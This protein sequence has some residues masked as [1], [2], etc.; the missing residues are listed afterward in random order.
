MEDF[1]NKCIVTGNR[2]YCTPVMLVALFNVTIRYMI[3]YLKGNICGKSAQGVLL[4]VGGVGYR[5]AVPASF[6]VGLKPGQSIELFIHTHVRE[7]A[8]SLYGFPSQQDMEVFELLISVSGV[9]PKVALA[10]MAHTPVPMIISAI[11]SGDATVFTKVSGVGKKTGERIVVDLQEKMATGIVASGPNA[12]HHS[13]TLDALTALGYSLPEAREALKK[14]EPGV[15]GSSEILKEALK[16][17]G[18]R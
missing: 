8:L 12:A 7:D 4:E 17:L 15:S 13:D 1:G 10:I 6:L 5:V 11:A 9:G 14:V 3:G 16:I 18:R 2:A